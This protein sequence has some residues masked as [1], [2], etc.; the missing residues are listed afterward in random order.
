MSNYGVIY[1]DPPWHFRT[2]SAKG[3]GRCADA[4][5]DVMT[6]DEIRA[7][8][9]AEYAA[10]DCVLLLWAIDPMLPHALSVIAA[11]GFEFK[12]VGFYWVKQNRDGS[13]F[14]GLGRWTRMN[15]EQC[16]LATRGRPRRLSAAVRKLISSPRREHSRKPDE[17]YER[18]ETLVAGPYLELFARQ[19]RPGWDSWGNEVTPE[20]VDR[21]RRYRADGSDI[22]KKVQA[23]S[24]LSFTFPHEGFMKGVFINEEE[25]QMQAYLVSPADR[26]V[27]GPYEDRAAA[28]ASSTK[29]DVVVSSEADVVWTGQVLVDV[30]NVLTDSDVKK[31]ESRAKG[32][33]RLLAVLPA[34]ARAP[35]AI[36]PATQEEGQEMAT[37]EEKVA[38]AAARE[39]KKA[40]RET[41]R[42][43]LAAAKAAKK[44]QVK[45]GKFS[46]MRESSPVAELL[47]TV[48]VGNATIE[49]LGGDKGAATLK[50]VRITH[51]VDHAI[52]ED[53][54][55]S[56]I[57]P[58]GKTEADLFKAPAPKREKV[59]NGTDRQKFAGE[60]T[61][62]LLVD[63]NP[64][65]VNRAA[66]KRFE[67]YRN[68][69]TVSEALAAGILRADLS[70][71]T[72]HG[73]ITVEAVV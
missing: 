21:N 2:W 23:G 12:T 73:F 53:G 11:W 70:W 34:V 45:L 40:E 16:L 41:K 59:A 64:K 61:I 19:E 14:M 26:R 24:L 31:F 4:W 35:V 18:I 27:V 17:V 28:K 10:K 22:A 47:K 44:R 51:G 20:F 57:L 13:P 1:A 36:Q 58:E 50:R 29:N 42:Q 72:G 8:P 32:V 38:K 52:G 68:G 56:L 54:V 25:P 6:L 55:V 33:A 63:K 7:L 5:Y 65:N 66:G 37:E 39:A 67:A 30:F 69:M 71:D 46:Q 43:E 3:R 9:V 62:K 60:A 49:S 15:P 48:L